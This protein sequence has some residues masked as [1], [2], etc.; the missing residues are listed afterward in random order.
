MTPSDSPHDAGDELA[1]QRRR[2]EVCVRFEKAWG[3]GQRPE[4]ENACLEVPE[5][6]RPALLHELLAVEVE[7]RL[8]IGE[9]PMP[10]EYRERF[11]ERAS[12]IQRL[13]EEVKSPPSPITPLW[14]DSPK[15]GLRPKPDP[16]LNLLFGL[17]ALQNNFIDRDTLL[18]AFNSWV[19]DKTH[20]IGQLLVER[21]VLDRNRHTMLEA[22][23]QE[24][25][26]QH[27]DNS[28]Q[29]LA[30][31]SSIGSM[32]QDFEQLADSELTASVAYV[33][34][35][36]QPS[37]PDATLTWVT[38]STLRGDRF[39]ILHPFDAKGNLGELFVAHDLELH[40]EV[41]LKQVKE[42]HADQGEVRARFL[43]EAEITGKLEHPGIVPVYG[44]GTYANGR[45]F[46]AMR[47]IQGQSLRDVIA[48][49]HQPGQCE[50]DGEQTLAFR[51]LLR[52]F[53]DVCNAV[54]Y[55]HSRGILHRDLKPANV[56]L[57]AYGETIVIDW[58]LAKPV[59][60]H[61]DL[62]AT[63]ARETF[64]LSSASGSP[65]T[66]AGSVIGTPQFMSPEQ[67]AG[68]PDRVG[69]A[70]DVYSLGAILYVLL[71]GSSP[72]QGTVSGVLDKV[73]QGEFPPPSQVRGRVPRALEA[74][75]L[76]A[77]ALRPEGR[78][79]S[80][81]EIA[82]E[83]E[84]WMADEPV[85]A[86]RESVGERSARWARHHKPLV[87]GAVVGFLL[88]P[89]ALAAIAI[90][91]NQ[92]NLA[93]RERLTQQYF[94]LVEPPRD[95]ARAP[96]WTWNRIS[97]LEVAAGLKVP[98][99]DPAQLRSEVAECLTTVDVREVIPADNSLLAL[100]PEPVGKG[101]IPD[102]SCLAFSPDGRYLAIGQRK[103]TIPVP[104]Q[105]RLVD[106][107]TGLARTFWPETG[108]GLMSGVG[109]FI[110]GESTEGARVITFGPQGRWLFVGTRRGWIH[111]WDT[112]APKS[113]R[114]SWLAH[115]DTVTG[116]AFDPE[117]QWLFTSSQDRTVKRWNLASIALGKSTDVVGLE[118]DQA[119]HCLGMVPG[120]TR[121]ACA[122]N[123][124]VEMID[125]PTLQRVSRHFS[126]GVDRFT[127]AGDGR[128]VA[129][130]LWAGGD[131]NG[132]KVVLL[133]LERGE[134]I[135]RLQDPDL[136][137]GESHERPDLDLEF[138]PDGSL[139]VSVG[140]DDRDRTVKL[141]EVASGRLLT[142]FSATGSL[143]MAFTPD[144]RHLALTT[145]AG[146]TL[147]ELGGVSV[148]MKMAHQAHPISAVGFDQQGRFVACAS[149]P[150]SLL[151]RISDSDVTIW[152]GSGG[153]RR[154]FRRVVSGIITS[155]NCTHI[156]IIYDIKTAI[157]LWSSNSIISTKFDSNLDST[158]LLTNAPSDSVPVAAGFAPER[159]TLWA[160][161][162]DT[163]RTWSVGDWTPR[164]PWRN[165]ASRLVTGLLSMRCLS[166]GRSWVV[167]GGR[168]G[169][170]HL[171]KT[172][173]GSS[174][175]K[176]WRGAAAP[177][178]QLAL[179]PDERMVALGTQDGSLSL[180][181][182]PDGRELLRESIHRDSIETIA[183]SPDGR[184]M[185][186]GSKDRTIQ[187]RSDS[188][189]F[190]RV[191][192]TLRT[193]IGAVLALAFSPDGS[194][195]CTATRGETAVRVWNLNK[196]RK[197]FG[198]MGL[199]WE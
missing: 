89:T 189:G 19:T 35:A 162:G 155:D 26:K 52:H 109:A 144:G 59:G 58:G 23:V 199:D 196:M 53:V 85:A 170:V 110:R 75:C 20:S 9:R 129:A 133:D 49:Y 183:F 57:G 160:A 88:V 83:V 7:L 168:D 62:A 197:I 167:V 16:A 185:A 81:A 195:L 113:Q 111:V 13:F 78:Y 42:T 187:I 156:R 17:L 192:L 96:G 5:S 37:D 166:V 135:R 32:R 43:V 145:A 190:A 8:A 159:N 3:G 92:R 93:E 148:Q 79:G 191:R 120:E 138:S 68:Q 24:H 126:L 163:V 177:L 25:L 73:R 61:L 141:W 174:P 2:V 182:I 106:R 173:D 143:D 102:A 80:A 36:C 76:K 103:T 64:P 34:A 71:T 161:V 47:R 56:M 97:E 130:S 66:V 65:E 181:T 38:S 77:M 123:G 30:A 22:L 14:T 147:Y 149:E 128:T 169:A 31:L 70:S 117:A 121:L 124:L 184:L 67:A 137:P 101:S 74:V 172:T 112:T 131:T 119:V 188:D 165:V 86:R 180:F 98:Q 136:L 6:E 12:S 171:F 125:G 115:S 48:A 60:H 46:Y 132:A 27:G 84:H 72:F 178:S 122:V 90:I 82:R 40:R 29:S 164:P 99:R 11:S 150:R 157:T 139:L 18:A 198:T 127:L 21:G 142:K 153:G 33:S 104:F 179:S 140:K 45:P 55:A 194:Q 114:F 91:W 87:T 100:G 15:A 118:F 134:E 151:G 63:P 154:L 4:I 1:A 186:T 193:P 54:A 158:P 39:R 28:E 105:V 10:E 176:S 94:N 175:A 41:L 116:I 108:A 50:A 152:D 146:V 95:T 44:L 69:P 107:D 51:K